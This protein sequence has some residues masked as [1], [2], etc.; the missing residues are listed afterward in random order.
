MTMK[1]QT[2][3]YAAFACHSAACAPPPAGR[4]GSSKGGIRSGPAKHAAAEKALASHFREDRMYSK[5]R[6]VAQPK[7]GPYTPSAKHMAIVG[8][9]KAASKKAMTR[10]QANAKAARDA[11]RKRV[12]DWQNLPKMQRYKGNMP[13]VSA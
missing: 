11:A 1:I 12:A 10:N 4:G 8:V 6:P 5:R 2:S 3:S 13:K 7:D 9:P